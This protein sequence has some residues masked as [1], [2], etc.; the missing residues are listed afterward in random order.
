M[1]EWR[2]TFL[3]VMQHLRDRGWRRC[4]ILRGNRL[5][6]IGMVGPRMQWRMR[7]DS[8]THHNDNRVRL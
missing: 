1:N 8:L 7:E 3:D 5:V 4:F 2:R 6:A